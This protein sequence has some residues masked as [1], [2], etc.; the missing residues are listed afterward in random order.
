MDSC[1]PRRHD[2]FIGGVLEPVVPFQT[3][4]NRFTQ[5]HQA[6]RMGVVVLIVVDGSFG[7]LDDVLG[8]VEVGVAA[9]HRDNVLESGSKLEHLGA[10][11]N[12]L[13]E[14]SS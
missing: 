11:R 3:F 4:R 6:R 7:G 1:T 9:A 14:D 2:D 12:V 13:L 10:E 8:R 5:L